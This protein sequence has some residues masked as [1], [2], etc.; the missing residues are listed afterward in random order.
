[1]EREAG[2]SFANMMNRGG[3]Q[4]NDK[5]QENRRK[6]NELEDATL[7]RLKAILTPEQAS[8]LPDRGGPGGQGAGGDG[9]A[10]RRTRGGQNG[11]GN[12][13]NNSGTPAPRR[14]RGNG[15]NGAAPR[16]ANPPA[17]RN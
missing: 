7:T 2:F 14:Q 8:K 13:G 16:D 5:A 1:E 15:G 3:G 4:D 9:Q 12:D 11:Q 6:R 17:P 10:G